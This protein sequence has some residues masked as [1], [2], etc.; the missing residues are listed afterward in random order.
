MIQII[1]GGLFAVIENIKVD[2][3][4]IGKQ[5]DKYENCTKFLELAKKKNIKVVSVEAGNKLKIDKNTFFHILWPASQDMI[6]E[7]GINNNSIMAKFCYKDFDI[8]FTGDIEKIAEEKIIKKYQNTEFLQ[9]DIL[10]V[11]HHGSKSSSIQEILE[12][13]KPKIAVIEV[14]KDNKYG[15]PNNDVIQRLENLRNKSL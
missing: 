8:L 12:K 6:E 13:I 10:K 7:N 14:G 4:I 3:I 1:A 15:H 11:A 9:S 2:T 5:A